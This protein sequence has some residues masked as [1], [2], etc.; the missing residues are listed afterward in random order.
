MFWPVM[1]YLL[2]FL[3]LSLGI[4]M[5]YTGWKSGRI[6]WILPIAAVD[7]TIWIL[8]VAIATE[9]RSPLIVGICLTITE[10]AINTAFPLTVWYL[11]SIVNK[12]RF[13]RRILWLQ[14]FAVLLIIFLTVFRGYWG[15]EYT[16]GEITLFPIKNP[17][18]YLSLLF[19]VSSCFIDIIIIQTILPMEYTRDVRQGIYWIAIFFIGIVWLVVRLYF[20]VTY[21]YGCFLVFF[22]L[23][24]IYLYNEYYQPAITSTVNLANYFY[25]M[26]KIPLLVLVR[27]GKIVQANNSAFAF[28][29]KTKAEL[30]GM[31][32]AEVFDFG[33]QAL[34]FSTK[35]STGNYIKRI[36]V[37]LPNS[38][39]T[40]EIDITYIYDKYKEF[41]CAIL[42]INDISDKIKLIGELKEAKR[43]AE[44][45]N[46][47]KS[48]FLANTSH[49][50]RTPMNAIIG[51]SDLILRENISPK[52]YEYTMDIKQ[53]G[54]NLLSI[55]NGILD[56]SK[57]ESG[58]MEIV[59]VHYYFRSVINDVVNIIRIRAMEKSLAFVTNIDSALPNDL[60]GDEVRI[61]QVLL[62]L[63]GNA[64]KYTERGFI[65]L[66]V[67]AEIPEER[68]FTEKS[69]ALKI[70]VEDCGI[71]IK[72][73][74]L[75]KVFG[76]F[77]Q[78]DAAA[79]RGIEGT[80]L[81]LTITRHLC[82]AMGG[83]V[84]VNSTYGR[85]S[86][87]TARVLQK[88]YS[89]E[90]F[91]AVEAPEEKTVLIYD[92]RATHADSLCWS[93]DN[94]GVSYTLVTEEEKFLEL[95]QQ[96]DDPSYKKYAFIFAAQ[97]LYEKVR[98]VLDAGK[99]ESRLVLLGEY[100]SESG[101][102]R[103][104]F[105]SLPV[106]TLS[107]ANILNH[108]TEMKISAERGRTTVKFTAPA[109]RILVVD[110]IP[111]NLKVAQ[112][113]LL[114]YHMIVDTCTTGPASIELF[115]KNEYDLVFMDHMIPGMDG[116]EATAVIRA[117]EKEKALKASQ[118]TPETP[119]KET[120]VIALT[121]NAI[122]GMKELF[123]RQGFNDYLAKPIEM[124]KLHEVLEKWIPRKKQIREKPGR[125]LNTDSRFYSG[126]FDG[127]TVAGIDLAA[128]MERYG[129][130]SVYL[131]ILRSYAAS[132]PDFLGT[133]RNV[134]K[135]TLDS[136]TVTVHGIKG[137]S[138]QICAGEAGREAELLEK[139][140]GA[141]DW[142][143]IEA[144]NGDF[145]RILEDLLENLGRFLAELAEAEE[146]KR[147]PAAA[148]PDP[149]LLER[150]LD[151]CKSYNT[152]IMEELLTELEKY[153]Y[154]SGANLVSWLRRQ[155]DNIEYD[156]IREHLE[157]ELCATTE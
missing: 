124:L 113:L 67:T 23:I 74:N 101:I 109:A 93:M 89:G 84:T 132:T 151:A 34:V 12:N 55:I 131:E 53:A 103:I 21:K 65:K 61:R 64:V 107:I 148:R 46:Q 114:P 96:E 86:V 54:A 66:S 100:G 43:R 62:N 128:G 137:S 8:G 19:S 80:G 37:K 60:I 20:P 150:L 78:V 118:E 51:M 22:I 35:A 139:A 4:Y 10:I 140:A 79:N 133:L 105:L 129:D 155:F 6:L 42:F 102:P 154:E 156:A 33:N 99:T 17:A 145:I 39:I 141:K 45:A 112:G 143:T 90:C 14:I 49:E 94:L 26:A 91:A 85:G 117:W 59:P 7:V 18:F 16:N 44:L 58:K 24:Y 92:N 30:I 73:E 142:D 123:L 27:D 122:S 41:Y 136:Y 97:A 71:G 104:R 95:L 115:K 116:I 146:G 69:F 108:K 121:A 153:A 72:E 126:V 157:K 47:A 82:R 56:F 87:F 50:I 75:D 57:I 149:V 76:E 111:T 1:L 11:D 2:S 120:P 9:S 125:D 81:G 152:V 28:F 32:M 83:D 106:H 38:S 25:S 144:R 36:E 130:D 98:P 5:V 135:E 147:R 68:N 134:S 88:I 52:V 127:K 48:A 3:S 13:I 70:V 110:D 77:T 63:L 119:P 15:V 40:C 138:Y 29:K 31:N